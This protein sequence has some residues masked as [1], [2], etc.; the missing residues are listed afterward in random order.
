M[1]RAQANSQAASD[2]AR[3]KKEQL[4][5][6]NKLRMERNSIQQSQSNQQN[7]ISRPNSNTTNSRPSSGQE[8]AVM[9]ESLENPTQ[10]DR[11]KIT[12]QNYEYVD[13]TKLEQQ[14]KAKHERDLEIYHQMKESSRDT[15]ASNPRVTASSIIS[16]PYSLAHI[17]NCNAPSANGNSFFNSPIDSAGRLVD[18]SD[19]PLLCMSSNMRNEIVVG[20]ADHALYSIDISNPSR[21]PITM[22]SKSAGHTDWITGVSHLAD[23][24]VS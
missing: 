24:R 4:E 17:R 3:K 13:Q 20:S 16:D 12:R 6:A 18:V 7:N 5:R 2:Y 9:Y 10:Y 21:S 14:A 23:G 19:R 22:Y 15:H 8:L 1:N 11:V